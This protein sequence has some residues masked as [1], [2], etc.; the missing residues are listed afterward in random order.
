MDEPCDAENER[1]AP[2]KEPRSFRKRY[3]RHGDARGH[4]EMAQK[5]RVRQV[6]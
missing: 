4:G 3:A 6:A 5:D 2:P 1:Q